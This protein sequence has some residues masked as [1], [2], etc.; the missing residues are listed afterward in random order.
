MCSSARKH[1]YVLLIIRRENTYCSGKYMV[2][3]DFL[4][5]NHIITLESSIYLAVLETDLS[6]TETSDVCG[7]RLGIHFQLAGKEPSLIA[8]SKFRK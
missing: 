3:L 5:K 7:T 4:T 2:H 6:C 1:E 8:K